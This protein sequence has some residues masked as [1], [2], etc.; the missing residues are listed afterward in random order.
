[1]KTKEEHDKIR[2]WQNKNI[3]KQIFFDILLFIKMI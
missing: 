1:M 3:E 2:I